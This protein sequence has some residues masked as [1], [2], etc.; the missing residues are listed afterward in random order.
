MVTKY[1]ELAEVAKEHGV[2]NL[3]FFFP[4]RP[5]QRIMGIGFTSSDDKCEVVEGR[6]DETPFQ[7]R[8]IEDNYKIVLQPLDK[9][10][11]YEEF[12]ISDFESLSHQCPDDFYV[13]V[14]EEKI[15]LHFVEVEEAVA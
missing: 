7:R 3:R 15:K 4:A 13:M 14:G 10:L 8:I 9:S 11:A 5:M 12:Y 2:E 6:A 1:V